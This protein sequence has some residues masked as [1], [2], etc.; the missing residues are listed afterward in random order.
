MSSQ[1]SLAW[2]RQSIAPPSTIM[3]NPSSLPRRL[4]ASS[5]A[6]A[7]CPSSDPVSIRLFASTT[8]RCSRGI[9]AASSIDSTTAIPLARQ[10]LRIS[11]FRLSWLLR[12]RPTRRCTPLA[13]NWSAISLYWFRC[14]TWA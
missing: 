14:S 6:S 2:P 5:T 9:D 4:I 12:S 3:K 13:S 7:S 11:S 1:P 10:V 8:S